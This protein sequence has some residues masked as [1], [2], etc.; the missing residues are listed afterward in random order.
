MSPLSCT[1]LLRTLETAY[2]YKPTFL[3]ARQSHP[4]LE[5]RSHEL[6]R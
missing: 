5:K 6:T 4:L 1:G 3:T 2:P